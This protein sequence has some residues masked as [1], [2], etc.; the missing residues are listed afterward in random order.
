[1]GLG[2]SSL[3]LFGGGGWALKPYLD[4]LLFARRG[5]VVLNHV[6]DAS[7]FYRDLSPSVDGRELWY[8][9]TALH[10]RRL[11]SMDIVTR[12]EKVVWPE[13]EVGRVY[14]WSPD[15]TYLALTVLGERVRAEDFRQRVEFP[16]EEQLAILV[17]TNDTRMLL[18]RPPGGID[19]DAMWL[20]PRRLIFT[21]YDMV[22]KSR[23]NMVLDLSSGEQAPLPTPALPL[24]VMD[25]NRVAYSDGLNVFAIT[26]APLQTNRMTHFR[27]GDHD[28][29]RWLRYDGGEDAFL[30]CARPRNSDKRLLYRAHAT[31]G[32]TQIL[33]EQDTYNGQ[34]LGEGGFAYVA[35]HDN[36]FQLAV[37]PSAAQALTTLFADDGVVSYTAA[38][39]RQSIFAIAAV[40]GRPPGLWCYRWQHDELIE[41]TGMPPGTPRA[42]V[43]EW[44]VNSSDGLRIPCVVVVPPRI[45]RDAHPAIILVPPRT[46]QFKRMWEPESQLLASLGFYYAAV[47]YRGCDGYG[48]A[49]SESGNTGMAINDVLA[50]YRELLARENIDPS[51]MYLFSQSDGAALASAVVGAQPELWRGVVFKQPGGFSPASVSASWPAVLLC[52]GDQDR[53]FDAIRRS[54]HESQDLGVDLRLVVLRNAGHTLQYY[55]LAFARQEQAILRFLA[56]AR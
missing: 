31:S 45:R 14:G 29:P 23:M 27:K 51:R 21:R 25:S 24:V 7:R 49:Y 4:A 32:H 52:M 28:P 5:E 10:G 13:S 41:L 40:E 30:F 48:R 11:H 36:V 33:N 39:L 2:L 53:S 43:V 56:T 47:N 6:L 44:S 50:L 22:S 55:P 34:W 42:R 1:M 9:A 18:E 54:V 19:A 20:T 38:P 35:N 12:R 26:L 15:G 37:M 17:A 46:G 3:A 16:Q 8:V